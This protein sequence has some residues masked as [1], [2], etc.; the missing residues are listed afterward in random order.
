MS[1]NYTHGVDATSSFDDESPE[2]KMHYCLCALRDLPL[3][4]FNDRPGIKTIAE[5]LIYALEDKLNGE[6]NNVIV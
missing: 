4:K 1:D 3:A 5:T 6:C 2:Q